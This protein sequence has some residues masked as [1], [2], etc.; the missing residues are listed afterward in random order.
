MKIY[1]ESAHT[2]QCLH[3]HT[4]HWPERDIMSLEIG[5]F[6]KVCDGKERFWL[7]VETISGHNITGSVGN[8]LVLNKVV[9]HGDQIECTIYDIYQVLKG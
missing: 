6:I 7:K 2:M 1:L 9:K 4:F 5:D 3:P 8:D